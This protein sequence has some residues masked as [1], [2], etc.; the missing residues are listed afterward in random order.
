MTGLYRAYELVWLS[1][2]YLIGDPCAIVEPKSL[3]N[4]VSE[5]GARAK[6]VRVVDD[7]PAPEAEDFLLYRY[8][9]EDNPEKVVAITAYDGD[10]AYYGLYLEKSGDESLSEGGG[11]DEA[12]K[13]IENLK[14]EI[15]G[16]I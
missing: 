9:V 14:R 2:Q 13:F 15:M 16:E 10:T 1:G 6:T 3:Q 8:G 7:S 11:L 12:H 5:L 4:I